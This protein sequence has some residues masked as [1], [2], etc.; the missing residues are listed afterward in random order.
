MKSTN[1]FGLAQTYGVHANSLKS[2]YAVI[3]AIVTPNE[4]LKKEYYLN[5]EYK[6]RWKNMEIKITLGS[7]IKVLI[8]TYYCKQIVG[9]TYKNKLPCCLKIST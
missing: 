3:K 7:Y 9:S 8:W 5:N 4:T 1:C 6:K 2:H